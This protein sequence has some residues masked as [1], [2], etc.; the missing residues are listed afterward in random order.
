L[1]SKSIFLTF[2]LNEILKS[3]RHSGENPNLYF[4]RNSNGKEID[5]LIYQDNKYYPIEIGKHSTPNK[6]DII[7]FSTLRKVNGIN[8]DYGY[9]LCLVLEPQPLS[10]TAIAISTWAI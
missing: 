4:Y 2:A 10:P 5:L 1:S 8:I 9:V 6:S 3:Y 7:S